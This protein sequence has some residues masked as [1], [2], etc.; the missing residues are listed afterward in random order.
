[1]TITPGWRR[2]IVAAV[3]VAFA[4]IFVGKF[5]WQTTLEALRDASLV[6]LTLATVINLASMFAKAWA[7]YLLLRPRAALRFSSAQ[8]ATYVG[9][10]VNCLSISVGGEAARVAVLSR[11]D[12]VGFADAAAGILASRVVEAL[13]LVGFVAVSSLFLTG[14]PWIVALRAT[15]WVLLVATLAALYSGLLRRGAARL[16]AGLQRWLAPL[17]GADRPPPLMLPLALGVVNWLCEW[18]TYHLCIEATGVDVPI[19]AS[20]AALLAANIGGIPRLTPANIGMMQASVAVALAP[21]GVPVGPAVAAGLVL[22]AVQ[23]LPT[24]AVGAALGGV[25]TLRDLKRPAPAAPP[26]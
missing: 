3:L 20:L 16:P 11:R 14:A 25:A 19:S 5:P 18:V 22:Q 17:I 23:T 12:G 1:M 8:V 24:I 9:A 13:A 21:F 26:A 10:A 6:V 2:A 15:S 4:V 7:W